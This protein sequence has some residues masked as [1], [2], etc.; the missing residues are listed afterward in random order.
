MCAALTVALWIGSGAQAQDF[1]QAI[2]GVWADG[3]CGDSKS[4][5][6]MVNSFGVMDFLTISDQLHFQMLI[7][8]R[9][10]PK[11]RGRVIEATL[12]SPTI[13]VSLD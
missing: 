10:E 8:E 12:L 6:R 3:D 4:R 11:E 7:F 9:I 2:A 1:P 5:V 13:N